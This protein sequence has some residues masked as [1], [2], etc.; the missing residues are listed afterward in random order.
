M[1]QTGLDG[2]ADFV[3]QERMVREMR[4]RETL[5]RVLLQQALEQVLALFGQVGRPADGIIANHAH[6]LKDRSGGE[7]RHPDHH[8]IND[9]A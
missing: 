6:Q 1:K 7:R 4:P 8:L 3:L 2:W 9:T 5:W